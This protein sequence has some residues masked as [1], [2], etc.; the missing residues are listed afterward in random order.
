RADAALFAV[1]A[2]TAAVLV[3]HAPLQLAWLGALAGKSAREAILAGFR[4]MPAALGASAL[5]FAG[6]VLFV[7]ACLCLPLAAHLVL[8]DHANVRLHDVVVLALASPMALIVGVTATAHDLARAAVID[9]RRLP[10]DA[11]RAGLSALTPRFV[12][13]HAAFA[14]AGALALLASLTF[15][16]RGGSA[17]AAICAVIAAHGFLFLRT[18]MRGAW[19]ARCIAATA[20][21]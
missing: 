6:G 17:A 4:R 10:I 8:K 15:S 16:V 11:V 14:T 12:G 7:L 5:V 21:A 19:L 13:L 18:L 20:T 2:A 3:L 1:A 9:P